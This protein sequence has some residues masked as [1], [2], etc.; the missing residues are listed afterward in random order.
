M[1]T[2]RQEGKRLLIETTEYQAAVLTEGYVSGVAEGSFVDRKTGAKD[3]GFGLLIA[4]FLLEPGE[5]APDTPLERRYP[6]GDAY[7]GNIPKRYV[8]LPQIC[9]QAKKLPNEIHRGQGY[10]AVRQWYPWDVACPPYH[11]G[12]KWEQHLLFPDGKRWFLGWDRFSCAD[13][14]PC[15]MMRLDMPGHV[16]HH[17]GDVF[18][19]IYLSYH[20]KPIPQHVFHQ[21]FAPDAQFLY[22]RDEKKLPQRLIRAIQLENGVWLAGMALDPAS[23]YEAWCH[24]RDY[25][26]F[27]EEFGGRAVKAG[28]WTGAV[29][30]VGYF[31]SI[32]EME[33]VYDAYRGA[34]GLRLSSDG[35]STT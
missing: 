17:G 18:R 35:W 20:G 7:H 5:D 22:R 32:A 16:K 9:T 29:H 21:N 13:D 3:P 1:A 14:A 26:C 33:Q 27:I 30:L 11:A 2:I 4:D 24:Q 19:Q 8:A 6:H 15:V 25:V 28:A 12:S 31:D 10:V 23:V 34:T